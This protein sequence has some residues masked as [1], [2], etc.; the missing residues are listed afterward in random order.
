M[1]GSTSDATI[2]DAVELL[3]HRDLFARFALKPPKGVRHGPPG[4][5]RRSRR[6][7][8]LVACMPAAVVCFSVK[9]P[10]CSTNT[11]ANPNG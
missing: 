2:K 3:T 4:N 11:W 8:A 6:P 7:G 9:G 10:N 1:A 5:G